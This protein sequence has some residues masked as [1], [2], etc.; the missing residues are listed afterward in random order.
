MLA[1][2][3]AIGDELTT[4]Q[5][6]DTNSQWLSQRLTGSGVQVLFHSTVGD[7][8]EPHVQ[9]LQQALTRADLVVS[10][11]GLGPTADDLTRYALAQVLGVDL[12]LDDQV[13]QHIR[14]LFARRQRPMP[15]RN[16]VQA[17]FPRGTRPIPNP[18]GTAPGIAA[19]IPRP[20]R[21]PAHLFAL[22]GV[23]AE[24][25]EMW[26]HCVGPAIA[27]LFGDRRRVIRHRCLKCFGVGE[28]ELEQML[29]D[30]IRRGRTPMVGIT[31]SQATIAL[32][33]TAEAETEDACYAVMEPTV[34]TIHQ[35]LGDLIFGQDDEELQDAVVRQLTRR[36]QTLAT[37]EYGSGGL[38]ARWLSDADPPSKAYRGGLVVRDDRGLARA[39]GIEASA[40][41]RLPPLDTL[42]PAIAERCRAA[43]QA[44]HALAIGPFPP[45]A[46]TPPGRFAYAV[47]GPGG[48]ALHSALF[49]GHPDLLTARSLKT[50]LNTLRLRLLTAPSGR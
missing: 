26:D 1:E 5:R 15:E 44:D 16:V 21:P 36:Q 50:A 19:E 32:R 18:H 20:G 28:S 2:V 48:T 43:Y 22:P 17:M 47:S 37:A 4:G 23:P 9:V 40:A 34:A 24:M 42:L 7:Q 11:G 29:P 14:D 33:I 35:C 38:L 6:L 27:A 31:V 25:H 3:I 13:L 39:A 49:A 12:A 41:A 8:L 10:S 46:T 30:L 45:P